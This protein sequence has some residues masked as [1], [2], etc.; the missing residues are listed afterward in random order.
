MD[1]RSYGVGVIGNCA[2]RCALTLP[3]LVLGVLGCETISAGLRPCDAL[4]SCSAD[5]A[6]EM[7][8]CCGWKPENVAQYR[9]MGSTNFEEAPN[10]AAVCEGTYRTIA[11]NAL[12][13]HEAGKLKDFPKSCRGGAE[14]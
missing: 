7:A 6:K 3:L 14:Q 4:R 10:A 1:T 2:R 9:R 11:Y 13:F 5:L 8:E 12:K